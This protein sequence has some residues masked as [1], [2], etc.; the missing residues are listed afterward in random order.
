MCK[1]KKLGKRKRK[2]EE[3]KANQNWWA[4]IV[5]DFNYIKI[6]SLGKDKKE[7]MKNNDDQIKHGCS[8]KT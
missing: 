5:F 2:T 4:E 7:R 8:R 3:S 6:I 1:K